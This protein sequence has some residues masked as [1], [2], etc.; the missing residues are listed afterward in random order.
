MQKDHVIGNYS[1]SDLHLTIT[2][3]SFVLGFGYGLITR[4]PPLAIIALAG[5]AALA[6]SGVAFIVSKP[7]RVK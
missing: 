4:K 2:A 5:V 6:G 1:Y 3:V 7:M